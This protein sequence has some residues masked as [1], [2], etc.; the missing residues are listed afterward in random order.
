MP[1]DFSYL[2]RNVRDDG[3][4]FFPWS[5]FTAAKYKEHIEWVLNGIEFD[6]DA[7][8]LWL[9][10]W[11]ERPT[12]LSDALVIVRTDF[13]KW[14]RLLPIYGHR[15]L[16]AEPCTPGNPVFS[17]KQTDIIYYGSNLAHYLI[18]E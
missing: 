17:I 12:E 9:H 6:V 5:K 11:G 10:R 16:A 7:N 3:D 14:P 2:L 15:F 4:V 18:N 8:N 1:S 13:A